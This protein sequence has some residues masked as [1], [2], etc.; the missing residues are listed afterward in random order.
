MGCDIHATV[1][2]KAYGSWRAAVAEIDL[3]RQYEVFAALVDDHPRSYNNQSGVASARGLPD[4]ADRGFCDSCGEDR[5]GDHTFSWL[6]PEEF[7]SALAKVPEHGYEY[8]AIAS[9]M[10]VLSDAVGVGSVRIVFGFD[11]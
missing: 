5:W 9:Y 2:V 11:N 8:A 1:E 7:S 4:D 10:R 6:D 3:P